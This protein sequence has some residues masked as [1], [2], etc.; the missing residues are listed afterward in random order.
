MKRRLVSVPDRARPRAVALT[1]DSQNMPAPTVSAT[2]QGELATRIIALAKEHDIPI[3]RDPDLVMLLA[4][5]DVGQ[6]IP[7]ELYAL[8]AEVLAFVYRLKGQN[9]DGATRP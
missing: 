3:R 4:Q 6:V 1:Y 2:G 7:P 5:L 9:A 8:V